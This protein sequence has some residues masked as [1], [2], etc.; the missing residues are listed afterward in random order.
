MKE[1]SVAEFRE[2]GLLQEVNRRL[3]HPLGLALEVVVMGYGGERFGRIWDFRDDPEGIVFEVEHEMNARAVL[4][5]LEWERRRLSRVEALGFMVQP[6]DE[7]VG[8][9]PLT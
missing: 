9:V 3:L 6:L 5:A 2:L 4:V 8:G 7:P 1:M